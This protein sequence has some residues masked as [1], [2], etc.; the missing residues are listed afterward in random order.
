MDPSLFEEFEPTGLPL[1]KAKKDREVV[2]RTLRLV[3]VTV[4]ASAVTSR[5]H[6]QATRATQM[7]TDQ[8]VLMCV[9]EK[10]GNDWRPCVTP[11]YLALLLS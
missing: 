7:R 10:M 6:I 2:P 4:D 9:Q 1:K 8:L 3:A 11:V 5:S